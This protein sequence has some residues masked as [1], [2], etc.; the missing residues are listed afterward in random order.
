MRCV[1]LVGN[2]MQSCNATREAY[3]PSIFEQN[4]YCTSGRYKFCPHYCKSET[5][6]VCGEDEGA[7]MQT[8]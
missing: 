3:V 7:R 6:N 5:A 1:F 8:E 4:E 2:Y